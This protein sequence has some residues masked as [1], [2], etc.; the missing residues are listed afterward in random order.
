MIP[1]GDYN[2]GNSGGNPQLYFMPGSE[3]KMSADRC[4]QPWRLSHYVRANYPNGTD[5]DNDVIKIAYNTAAALVYNASMDPVKQPGQ[6]TF[7][8]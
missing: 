3:P 4:R 1:G 2:I 7:K 5:R 8:E 6:V